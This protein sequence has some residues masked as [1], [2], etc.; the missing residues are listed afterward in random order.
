MES[1]HFG[2]FLA[3]VV[4]LLV[5]GVRLIEHREATSSLHDTQPA[6]ERSD[7][8]DSGDSHPAHR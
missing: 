2:M 1:I 4:L 8:R 3:A 7:S 5:A 6:N